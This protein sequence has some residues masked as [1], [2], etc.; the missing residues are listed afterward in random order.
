M[1]GLYY[2]C[3][4][5]EF[6][7]G[8]EMGLYWIYEKMPERVKNLYRKSFLCSLRRKGEHKRKKRELFKNLLGGVKYFVTKVFWLDIWIR[9]NTIRSLVRMHFWTRLFLMG[10]TG[11]SLL[12]S[13]QTI[14]QN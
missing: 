9:R 11:D 10:E 12:I 13:G 2:G 6:F 14:P 5:N 4:I 3:A 1:I 7:G 8:K